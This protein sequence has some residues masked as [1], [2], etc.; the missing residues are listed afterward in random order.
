MPST[1]CP[2]ACSQRAEARSQAFGRTN[3]SPGRCMARNS[4]G[5]SMRAAP[6]RWRPPWP[7]PGARAGQARRPAPNA[8]VRAASPVRA[9]RSVPSS[10]TVT[11]SPSGPTRRVRRTGGSSRSVSGEQLVGRRGR[12]RCRPQ[13]GTLHERG[14]GRVRL[15]EELH[16]ERGVVELGVERASSHGERPSAA[17][18]RRRAGAR[19][20]AAARSRRRRRRNR[21]RSRTAPRR[22]PRAAAASSGR[23]NPSRSARD[24]TGTPAR[25]RGHVGC[26]RFGLGVAGVA[27]GRRGGRD[28][29]PRPRG[30]RRGQLIGIEE[31]RAARRAVRGAARAA[32][33]SR[34]ARPG[35]GSEPSVVRAAASA[36]GTRYRGSRSTRST[37]ARSMSSV[38]PPR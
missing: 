34:T 29:R 33:R 4:A 15:H 21:R 9:C 26:G 35:S 24:A 16:A 5:V 12:S 22:R 28:Q 17:A 13:H 38:M 1:G 14:R 27:I 18:V 19:P 25:D 6:R 11:T 23:S 36:S 32:A 7:R 3:G 2:A 30:G 31:L 20:R 37:S 8:S 10:R